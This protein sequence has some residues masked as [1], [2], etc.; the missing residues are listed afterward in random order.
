LAIY[1]EELASVQTK[2]ITSMLQKLR[3]SSKLPTEIR[4]GPLELGGLALMD[5]RT[6]VGISTIKYM[7][8]SIYS[9]T[10]TGKLMVLNVKYSQIE[11][12]ISE[13][14]L[15]HPAILIPY[16]TPTWTIPIRQFLCQ[17]NLTVSLT[18]TIKIN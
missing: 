13:P 18:D 16:M 8:D 17:H 5:L 3:Y 1:E 12:G 10:E 7:R 6:E 14:L 2:V 11:A 15:E 9:E 4:H